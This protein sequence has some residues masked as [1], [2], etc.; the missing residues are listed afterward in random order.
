MRSSRPGSA[1]AFLGMLSGLENMGRLWIDPCPRYLPARLFVLPMPVT[2]SQPP[3]AEKLPAVPLR[4]SR[5]FAALIVWPLLPTL[6]Y[7][8]VSSAVVLV[9][10]PALVTMPASD[11]DDTLVPPNTSQPFEP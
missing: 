9:F 1:S 4:M 5:K 8:S 2:K 11:G 6:P 10:P 3:L 7:R